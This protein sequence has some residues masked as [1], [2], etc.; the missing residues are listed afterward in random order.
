VV[1]FQP[2]KHYHRQALDRSLWLGVFDF[3]WLDFI[4]VFNDMRAKTF[5]KS[6]IL[7][8]FEKTGLIPYNPEKVLTPLREK[9][10]KRNPEPESP[11]T[12]SSISSNST[13][14][15]PCKSSDMRDYAIQLENVL[16]S[17]EASPTICRWF[18]CFMTAS[19]TKAVVDEEAEETLCELK[20]EMQERAKQQSG[21]RRVV[22]K[23]G[24]LTGSEAAERI[25]SRRMEEVEQ[26]RRQAILRGRRGN[27][28]KA[29]I[30]KLDVIAALD[31]PHRS[32]PHS[33]RAVSIWI[34][35]HGG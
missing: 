2:F 4:A 28:R 12:P 3:N 20:K 30:R 33:E 6:T 31:N 5:K 11:S 13:W 35:S 1:C 19:L 26:A 22:A 9:L 24:V 8:A 14:P 23:G 34:E 32:A 16:E 21:T 25:R 17:I 10:E 18:N 7:S 27:P 29:L 15:T